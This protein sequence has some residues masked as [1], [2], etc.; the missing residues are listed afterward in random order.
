MTLLIDQIDLV[1]KSLNEGKEVDVISLEFSKAFDK[2]DNNMLFAELKL[3][4]IT[5]KVH[6]CIECFSVVRS[7]R[8]FSLGSQDVDSSGSQGT[9][10][11]PQFSIVYIIH[12]TS[13]ARNSKVL[14][15]A[16]D[17]KLMKAFNELLCEIRFEEGLTGILQWSFA[18]II[19]LHE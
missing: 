14:A 4:G 13:R 2:V 5:E 12:K 19:L 1:L 16:D 15:I 10:L 6:Q 8:V 3:Y 18:N 9:A 7:S 17:T 11:E